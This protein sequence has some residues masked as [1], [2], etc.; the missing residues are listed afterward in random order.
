MP[1]SDPRTILL[2]VLGWDG[3][4]SRGD[5]LVML[6]FLAVYLVAMVRAE[7]RASEPAVEAEV[8]E[9]VGPGGS[10]AASVALVVLGVGMLVVGADQLVSGASALARSSGL[11]EAVI[12]LTVMAVGTS[13][14][15]L[16]ASLA[17]ARKG[18]GD[19]VLGNV[20]GSNVFNVLCI[21][22]ATA[23]IRPIEG[24]MGAFTRDLGVTVAFALVLWPLLWRGRTL[25]RHEAALLL[26]GWGA[27]TWSLL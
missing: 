13:L 8:V 15:E 26:G 27:Y 5:G 7:L 17:A 2:V 9:A 11:S 14:P 10:R 1:D 18:Q 21:L 20:V 12:G 3:S 25:F 19:I 16:A 4:L 6:A 23:A 24:A 22:G